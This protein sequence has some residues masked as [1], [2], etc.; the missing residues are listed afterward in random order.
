MTNAD[1]HIGKL[2]DRIDILQASFQQLTEEAAVLKID[3]NRLSER[4]K[5][6]Q[7]LVEKLEGEYNRWSSQVPTTNFINDY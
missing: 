4:L 7:V 6:A 1:L 5:V 3:L 2:S